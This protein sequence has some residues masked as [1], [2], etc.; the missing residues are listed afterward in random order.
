MKVD[1]HR[2][3]AS[4]PNEPLHSPFLI[5]RPLS[6]CLKMPGEWL[7]IGSATG[8][9]KSTSSNETRHQSLT[10]YHVGLGGATPG[11][12]VAEI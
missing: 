9:F 11:S 2:R 10:A 3:P 4:S 6:P 8:T 1:A 7:T 5:L 12:M